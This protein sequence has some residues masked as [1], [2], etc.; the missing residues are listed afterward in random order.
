MKKQDEVTVRDILMAPIMGGLF[1]FSFPVLIVG[2][3]VSVVYK[4][5]AIKVNHWLKRGEEMILMQ[6][7]PQAAYL[8]PPGKDKAIDEGK[9]PIDAELKELQ[10]EVTLKR[11][12]ED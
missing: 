5:T 8:Q 2:T 4:A 10:N 11:Q 3:V 12:E 6:W 9:P 1:A 7:N